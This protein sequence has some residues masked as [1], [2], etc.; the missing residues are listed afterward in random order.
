M[1]WRIAVNFS[2]FWDQKNL[3]EIFDLRNWRAVAVYYNKIYSKIFS[4]PK[5]E[6]CWQLRLKHSTFCNIQGFSRTIY[7]NFHELL[8]TRFKG[9]KDFVYIEQYFTKFLVL[10]H[11]KSPEFLDTLRT[12]YQLNDACANINV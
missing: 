2:H 5:S 9:G 3:S 6:R 7:Q 10:K 1:H 8:L 12:M 11:L 4:L